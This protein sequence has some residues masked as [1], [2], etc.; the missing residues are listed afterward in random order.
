[1]NVHVR[2]TE[3]RLVQTMVCGCLSELLNALRPPVDYELERDDF[4]EKVKFLGSVPLF[5]SQLPPAEL[6]KVAMQLKRKTWRPGSCLV[7]QFDTGRALYIIHSGEAQ[8]VVDGNVRCIL[9]AGD[10]FGGHTLTTERPNIASILAGEHGTLNTLSLSRERFQELGLRRWLQFPKRPALYANAPASDSQSRGTA[11]GSISRIGTMHGQGQPDSEELPAEEQDF[12]RKALS[13][14]SNLRA[15]MHASE[16]K[17]HELA[18]TAERRLVAQGDVVAESGALG[19]EF[20]IVGQGS[21]DVVITDNTRA[22]GR[23]SA[24]AAVANAT[25]VHRFFAQT[26]CAARAV[27]PE[28]Q[29]PCDAI[30]DGTQRWVGQRIRRNAQQTQ[31]KRAFLEIEGNVADQEATLGSC[32]GLQETL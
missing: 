22:G 3:R 14:N 18:A 32:H 27:H 15:M 26:A 24:E 12:I 17:L 16:D 8:V 23:L 10:Y 2:S 4:E 19:N 21:L 29:V 9:E 31:S 1:L 6:P 13:S 7:K 30:G 28:A 25:M 5:H 11:A 20:F